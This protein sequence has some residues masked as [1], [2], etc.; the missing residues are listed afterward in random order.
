M[1]ILL[2]AGFACVAAGVAVLLSGPLQKV[3]DSEHVF[4]SAVVIDIG[5]MEPRE[6]RRELVVL[7]NSSYGVVDVRRITSSC[8]CTRASVSPLSVQ[9]G[10]RATVAAEIVAPP[11]AGLVDVLVHIDG[12]SGPHTQIRFIGVVR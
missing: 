12:V 1:R 8:G 10:D 9:P 7:G 3:P 6:T 4:G 2:M 5:E 11:S